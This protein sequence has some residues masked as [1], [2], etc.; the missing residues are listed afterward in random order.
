MSPVKVRS[1]L[2]LGKLTHIIGVE[3]AHMLG[4]SLEVL[5]QYQAIGARYP[6]LSHNCHNIF[7][8]SCSPSAPESQKELHGGL[9]A[10]SREL[11]DEMNRLDMLVDLSHTSQQQHRRAEH[12]APMRPRHLQPFQ[13]DGALPATQEFLRTAVVA[14]DSDHCCARTTERKREA[15]PRRA[16]VERMPSWRMRNGVVAA[17]AVPAFNGLNSSL[18]DV[19]DHIEQLAA[20]VGRHRVAIGMGLGR[21]LERPPKGIEDVPMYSNVVTHHTLSVKSALLSVLIEIRLA[22]PGLRR[23]ICALEA[24]MQHATKASRQEA[25]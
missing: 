8:N 9:S 17:T 21:F 23:S 2:K 14:G 16:S 11:V 3:G 1:N 10:R 22:S 25:S 7:A 20:V 12:D 15:S 13:Q 19:S 4:N 18:R 24:S 6:T 5:R